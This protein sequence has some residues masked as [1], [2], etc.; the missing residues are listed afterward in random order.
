M[1]EDLLRA[2]I[3]DRSIGSVLPDDY[4][5]GQSIGSVMDRQS[6]DFDTNSDLIRKLMALSQGLRPQP[7]VSDL[8]LDR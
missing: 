7:M 1:N 5:Q 4:L 2:L 3:D 6:G 8:Q